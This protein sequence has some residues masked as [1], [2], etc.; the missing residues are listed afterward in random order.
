MTDTTGG[1]PE[2]TSPAGRD[3]TAPE[4]FVRP[5][6][7]VEDR[8]VVRRIGDR[9][10]FLGNR[11][12]ADPA[13]HDRE[14]AYV[15]TASTDDY[16]L[17][18]HH[19]PLDDGPG[20]DWATFADAVDTARRLYRRDGALLVHCKAGISRSTTL[21]ATTI[22]AEEGWRFHDA[23]AIVQDARPYA[24][25]HPALHEQAVYYLAARSERPA[26]PDSQ[27]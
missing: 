16:P 15:L 2:D 18:T 27:R 17:T 26:R 20:N 14:F 11:H 5:L 8:A 19:R 9:D 13:A 22:A 6:G 12:A 3:A 1:R 4:S 24:V 21:L 10:L 7:Y 23:L 25:P